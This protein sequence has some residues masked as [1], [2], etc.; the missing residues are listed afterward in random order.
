MWLSQVSSQSRLRTTTYAT[1]QHKSRAVLILL[2]FI[3][4]IEDPEGWMSLIS[5]HINRISSFPLSLYKYPIRQRKKN[6]TIWL[7]T[8]AVWYCV[9]LLLCMIDF[10]VNI[11]KIQALC[12]F[13]CVCEWGIG[14]HPLSSLHT[15][16]IA[17]ECDLDCN[18]IWI[19][20]MVCFNSCR[21]W[22]QYCK[23]V[24]LLSINFIKLCYFIDYMLRM[25]QTIISPYCA[26]LD[27]ST[28]EY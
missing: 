27:C 28:M 17:I 16:F 10:M 6:I 9:V 5:F 12:L 23:Q 3:D 2:I 11:S 1:T 19:V 13:F 25:V 7:K 8:Q 21:I 26:L 15:P 4:L 20:L 18:A 24:K 14:G 22:F